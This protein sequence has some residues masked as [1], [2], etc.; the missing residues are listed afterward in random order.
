M[1]FNSQNYQFSIGE[2]HSKNVVLVHFHYNL[3]WKDELKEKFPSAKWSASKNCWYLPD[4]S[5]IRNEIGMIPK[6]EMG[7]TVISKSDIVK[8]FAQV[9]NPKH[10]LMLKLCPGMGLRVSEIVNLKVTNIWGMLK[11]R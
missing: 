11:V 10:S 3:L 2:H 9:G 4:T 8:L 5:S 6:T 1:S 7:K